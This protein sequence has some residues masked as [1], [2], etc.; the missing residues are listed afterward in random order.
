[1]SCVCLSDSFNKEIMI[2]WR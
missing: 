2:F 1:M